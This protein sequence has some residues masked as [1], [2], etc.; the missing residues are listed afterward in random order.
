MGEN[1]EGKTLYTGAIG[2]D[3]F[4]RM[5]I[6]DC[7][8]AGVDTLFYV[9]QEEPTSTCASLINGD[10]GHRSMISSLAGANTYPTSYLTQGKYTHH[11]YL[12]KI[13]FIKWSISS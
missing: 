12:C 13:F 6:K 8:D 11:K 10:V 1:D 2:K 9:Q 5:L 4:G 7:E 3:D